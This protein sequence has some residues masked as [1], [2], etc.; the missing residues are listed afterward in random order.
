MRGNTG[1]VLGDP[2]IPDSGFESKPERLGVPVHAAG[3]EDH[4]AGRRT[5]RDAV[6]LSVQAGVSNLQRL[7][8]VAVQANAVGSEESGTGQM[9]TRHASAA[10]VDL[11]HSGTQRRVRSRSCGRASRATAGNQTR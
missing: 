9:E 8:D 1:G 3:R 2:E 11:R 5:A 4:A 7:R 6:E 10:T